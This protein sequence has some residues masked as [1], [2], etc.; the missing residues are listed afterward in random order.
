[1]KDC[2]LI[3]NSDKCFENCAA[4]SSP[5]MSSYENLLRT[6]TP[7]K[8]TTIPE[9]VLQVIFQAV[10]FYDTFISKL[11]IYIISSVNYDLSLRYVLVWILKKI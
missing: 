5:V 3:L 6:P 7:P 4:P 2:T 10:L 1:M 9:D 11:D 8:V